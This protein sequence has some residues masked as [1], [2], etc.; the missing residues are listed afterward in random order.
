MIPALVLNFSPLL[1]VVFVA[2]VGLL[3]LRMFVVFPKVAC[4][5]CRARN[6]CPNAQ[7]MGLSDNPRA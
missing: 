3:A 4:V 1:L 2:V 7:S 5:H 6:I